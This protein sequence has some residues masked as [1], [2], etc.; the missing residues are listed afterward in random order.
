MKDL[1]ASMERMTNVEFYFLPI[2]LISLE[3]KY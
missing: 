1:L 3:A 2:V